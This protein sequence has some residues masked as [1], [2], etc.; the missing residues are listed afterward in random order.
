MSSFLFGE[1]II[2][3]EIS[4][5][6]KFHES[7]EK[8]GTELLAKTGVSAHILI[9]KTTNNRNLNIIGAEELDK[10]TQANK[11]AVILTFAENEQKVDIV[12]SP[13]VLTMFDKEQI[14]SPYPWVGTI[15]PILG[16][17]IKIDPREKYSVALFNGFADIVEQIAEHKQ[18][19]LENSVGNSNKYVLNIIRAI[20]YSIIFIALG[21][22]LLR[23]WRKNDR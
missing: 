18:I 23:T 13:D 6:Q 9:L 22:L 15:L 3:D 1:V 2:K 12:A 5:N 21:Y 10:F 8:I 14:L 7:I 16:E 4:L 17:K 11:Q 20:F 19:V